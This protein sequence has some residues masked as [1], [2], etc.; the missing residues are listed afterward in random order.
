MVNIKILVYWNMYI[1]LDCGMIDEWYIGMWLWP[2]LRYCPSICLQGLRNA[3]KNFSQD[4]HLNPQ[5][6][7]AAVNISKFINNI[8]ICIKPRP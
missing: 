1:V 6:R 2:V 3:M 5:C 8:H 4:S 7:L